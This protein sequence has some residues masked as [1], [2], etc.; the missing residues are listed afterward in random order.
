M[1]HL[2]KFGLFIIILLYNNSHSQVPTTMADFFMPG[3][4]PLESGDLSSPTSCNCHKFDN[5]A[6][7]YFNWAG[8][9]M[10]QSM[11]DPL[12]TA[13]MAIAIQDADPS[14]YIFYYSPF[15]Q[16]SE[17]CGTCHDV[18][19]PVFVRDPYN[20]GDP[21]EYAAVSIGDTASTFDPYEQFPVENLFRVVDECLQYTRWN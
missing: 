16:D 2:N 11:R 6:D 15:H 17:L 19:N 8:S 12:C 3:S 20:I 18:S 10:A 14:G 1:K 21:R 9:M 4:Q 13:S 7:P 5:V